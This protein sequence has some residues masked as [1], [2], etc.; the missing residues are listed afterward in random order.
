MINNQFRF[1]L[2]KE[3]FATNSLHNAIL[4]QNPTRKKENQLNMNMS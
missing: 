2:G 4:I 1:F 3:I